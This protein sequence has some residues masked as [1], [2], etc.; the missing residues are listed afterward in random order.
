MHAFL[1]SYGRRLPPS[2]P[3]AAAHRDIIMALVGGA[4]LRAGATSCHILHMLPT[5]LPHG[6]GFRAESE[7]LAPRLTLLGDLLLSGVPRLTGGTLH[8]GGTRTGAS[9]H[10]SFLRCAL[11][12][13]TLCGAAPAIAATT[14]LSRLTPPAA[15]TLPRTVGPSRHPD[16]PSPAA[17][18]S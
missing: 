12:G 18:I 3:G 15:Q 8:R 6:G 10:P 11:P 9:R 13:V 2:S 14:R 16:P 1:P 17:D 7:T 4:C 5:G